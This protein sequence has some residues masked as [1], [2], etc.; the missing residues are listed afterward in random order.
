MFPS[1]GRSAKNTLLSYMHFHFYVCNFMVN[2][3]CEI[4]WHCIGFGKWLYDGFFKSSH[5]SIVIS[6]SC[7]MNMR[8]S[9]T[10]DRPPGS[11]TH[12]NTNKS[13]VAVKVTSV[14]AFCLDRVCL[15]SM[16]AGP[17]NALAISTRTG[18]YRET[19]TIIINDWGSVH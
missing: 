17:I 14:I 15:H 13:P 12:L 6:F 1:I 11:S 2:K 16:D 7:G 3:I 8:L 10:A 9:L 5:I 4:R 19:V 18:G